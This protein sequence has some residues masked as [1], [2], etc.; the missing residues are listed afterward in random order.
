M[1]NAPIQEFIVESFNTDPEGRPQQSAICTVF[2]HS[3]KAAAVKVLSENL[4][5]IGNVHRLRARVT[6]VD[7]AGRKSVTTLYS[8]L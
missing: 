5:E 3:A 7:A 1:S 8:Q 6:G 2:A 4:Y